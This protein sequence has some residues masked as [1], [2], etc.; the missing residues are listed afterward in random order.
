VHTIGT[1]DDLDPGEL[2]ERPVEAG[3][4]VRVGRVAG[5]TARVPDLALA[6]ELLE[7]PLRAEVGV[8]LL[9]VVQV[10]R[11]RVGHE[12]VDR[13]G[14]DARG[15]RLGE[16][17]VEGR[18]VVRVEHDRVDVGSDQVADIL[19]LACGIRVAVNGLE[20]GDLAGRQ[21]LGLGGADL[22]LAEPVTDAAAVRVADDVPR[23]RRRRGGRLGGRRR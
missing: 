9:V 12:R 19:Q 11:R 8:L 13:D 10:V 18:G 3:V 17:R 23:G 22:L 6:A 15:I 14:L 1:G 4:A 21:G 7:Q 5:E 20:L 16:G 2:A